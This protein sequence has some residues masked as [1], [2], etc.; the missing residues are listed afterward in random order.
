[1]L[2]LCILKVSSSRHI[3][4]C[5]CMWAL[6]LLFL[7]QLYSHLL[8]RNVQFLLK[9]TGGDVDAL[10]YMVSLQRK[11]WGKEMNSTNWERTEVLMFLKN[12]H[13][14][15]S[16]SPAHE[17]THNVPFFA[18]CLGSA[19]DLL[20]VSDLQWSTDHLSTKIRIYCW[21]PEIIFVFSLLLSSKNNEI[22]ITK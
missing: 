4:L 2:Y 8:P 20:Y 5:S 19:S 10:V 6:F 22:N 16:S 13:S 11:K 9:P 17:L 18:V 7:G 21:S 3:S 14:H 15:N 1:M 12:K